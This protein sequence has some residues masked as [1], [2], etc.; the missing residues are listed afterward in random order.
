MCYTPKCSPSQYLSNDIWIITLTSSTHLSKVIEPEI[1][2][3]LYSGTI[4]QQPTTRHWILQT[5]SW[6]W[7]GLRSDLDLTWTW[8][9]LGS[10]LDLDLTWIWLGLGSDLDL[11]LTWTWIWLGLGSNSDFDRLGLESDLDLDLTRTWIW[12]GLGSNWSTG[13]KAASELTFKKSNTCGVSNTRLY[14]VY[15]YL[16]MDLTWTWI[17]LELG[18]DLT[19]TWLGLGSDLNLDLTWTWIWDLNFDLNRTWIWLWHGSVLKKKVQSNLEVT[20]RISIICVSCGLT[21]LY[22]NISQR[23]LLYLPTELIKVIFPTSRHTY[24]HCCYTYWNYFTVLVFC[25]YNKIDSS[26]YLASI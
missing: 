12:L 11:D 26:K 13:S 22:T 4:Q 17:W 15:F 21:I 2:L 7:L 10:D 14:F 16:D 5:W 23:S 20:F 9:W 8:I 6:I 24:M 25:I 19:W 18:S 3:S 1:L